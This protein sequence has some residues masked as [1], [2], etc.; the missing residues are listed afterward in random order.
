MGAGCRLGRRCGWV[1]YLGVVWRAC[2]CGTQSKAEGLPGAW[3]HEYKIG[4]RV[5]EFPNRSS[6]V[7]QWPPPPTTP[8]AGH[9]THLAREKASCETGF[10]T[11]TW[12]RPGIKPWK[13][14][15][16]SGEIFSHQLIRID[17]VSGECAVLI[18]VWCA[19][20]YNV[21]EEVL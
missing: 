17:I 2:D 21:L 8:T 18:C 7:G 4:Q 15:V 20:V 5:H 16:I 1:S 19:F 6:N 14:C 13:L 3:W 10:V 11:I 9:G 12:D